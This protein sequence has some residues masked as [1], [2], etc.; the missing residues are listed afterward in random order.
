MLTSAIEDGTT[1]DYFHDLMREC[2]IRLENTDD[3]PLFKEELRK[4]LKL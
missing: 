1:D 2:A 4:K 3:F